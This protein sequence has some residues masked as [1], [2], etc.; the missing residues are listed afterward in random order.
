MGSLKNR[1]NAR[2]DTTK[3]SGQDGPFAV[4]TVHPTPTKLIED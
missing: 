4:P 1:R 2:G 3:A